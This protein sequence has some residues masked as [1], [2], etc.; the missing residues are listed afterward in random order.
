V[1]DKVWSGSA[2][3]APRASQHTQVDT[4]CKP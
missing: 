1:E 4:V 3:H 2:K